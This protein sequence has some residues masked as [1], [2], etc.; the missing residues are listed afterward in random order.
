MTAKV[1]SIENVFTD[2]STGHRATFS[3]QIWWKSTVAKFPEGRVVYQTKKL[4]LRGTRPSPY[5]GQ[6]GLIAP[7]SFWTLS[8]IDL[9]TFTEFG[10]H[11][12]RFAGLIPEILIFRPKK[13]IHI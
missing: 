13:S 6:N 9:S 4:G 8:T 11:R 1:K 5:F 2:S 12:L 3:D 7:K 10:P